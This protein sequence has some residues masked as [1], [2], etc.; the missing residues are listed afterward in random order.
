[1]PPVNSNI[2]QDRREEVLETVV[3]YMLESGLGNMSL[4]AL[5]AAVGTSDRMLLYYF[6]DKNDLMLSAFECFVQRL[7]A[8]LG[9]MLP[10]GRQSF[11]VLLK[12]MWIMLKAP[13]YEPYVRIWYDALGHA[14]H[15]EELYRSM[16]NRVVD[17]WLDFFESRLNA[18]PAQC[19][20]QI[21]A[22]VA[23][24]CGLVMMRY[25]GRV[26][27][28]DVAADVLTRKVRGS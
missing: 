8:R 27:E 24:V 11:D 10:A 9:E 19:R 28:A 21:A 6:D 3:D 5:A 18:P 20:D 23:A 12:Q 1:M 26:D 16:T 15:G 2:R 14:S 25:I 22:L 13:E 7:S 17:E 4:R